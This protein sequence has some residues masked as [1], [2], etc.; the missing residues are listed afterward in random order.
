MQD[1]WNSLYNK[2][3]ILQSLDECGMND[4]QVIKQK[5]NIMKEIALVLVEEI[6]ALGFVRSVNL[7][8]GINIHEE[9]RIYEIHLLQSA[10]E[11]TGGHRT[12]AAQIL[13]ISLTTLHNK[14]KRFNISLDKQIS[15]PIIHEDLTGSDKIT[16]NYLIESSELIIPESKT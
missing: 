15:A 13:G 3:G 2:F 5:L 11:R 16:L 6:E 12:K 10:L 9:M 14:L 8:R 4:I 7:R 1:N